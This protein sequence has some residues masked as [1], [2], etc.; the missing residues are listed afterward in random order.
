ML[1]CVRSNTDIVAIKHRIETCT[2]NLGT[3]LRLVLSGL[4]K[5][6]EEYTSLQY[7][8]EAPEKKKKRLEKHL[9]TAINDFVEPNTRAQLTLFKE[10][11]YQQDKFVN[12]RKCVE[13][14]EQLKTRDEY[15]L[16]SPK[17]TSSKSYGLTANYN[18]HMAGGGLDLLPFPVKES[19]DPIQA[20]SKFKNKK[21]K[22]AVKPKT[23]SASPA[24]LVD[25]LKSTKPKSQN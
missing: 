7:P 13:F 10:V 3:P 23:R 18:T 25:R 20:P 14:N 11:R 8:F 6:V 5:L 9:M 24:K 1:D 19:L 15:S 22:K 4:S 2:R 17:S 12:L 16:K 21:K